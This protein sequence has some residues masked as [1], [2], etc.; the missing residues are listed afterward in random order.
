[1]MNKIK[2]F[3][4]TYWARISE[5][6]GVLFLALLFILKLKDEKIE[7][8]KVQIAGLTT[9][10]DSDLLESKIKSD[11][12]QIDANDKQ[13]TAYNALLD[14]LN[15]KRQQLNTSSNLTPQQIQN[16]WNKK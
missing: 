15:Q 8:Y 2:A 1:M 4:S 6:V 12:S 3:F 10:K 16:Y 9:Q 14:Q 11:Q 13:V 5:V 7:S